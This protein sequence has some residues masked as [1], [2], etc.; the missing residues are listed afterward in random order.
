MAEMNMIFIKI[1]TTRPRHWKLDGR[2][3]PREAGQPL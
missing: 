3:L 1:N 2:V